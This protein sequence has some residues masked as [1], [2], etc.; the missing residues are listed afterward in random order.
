MVRKLFHVLGL[1]LF[2]A[3]VLTL[4]RATLLF[5]LGKLGLGIYFW[6]AA[7]LLLAGWIILSFAKNRTCRNCLHRFDAKAL[8]CPHCGGVPV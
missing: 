4:F 3:G 1:V 8:L 5:S 7:M 2:A 6:S